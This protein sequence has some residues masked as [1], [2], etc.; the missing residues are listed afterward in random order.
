MHIKG[1]D[2]LKAPVHGGIHVLFGT[3]GTIGIGSDGQH[4][5]SLDA[6]GAVSS[7]VVHAWEFPEKRALSR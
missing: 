3:G 5:S 7:Q 1:I 6:L 2:I 4:G